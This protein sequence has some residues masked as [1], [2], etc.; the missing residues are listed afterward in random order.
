LVATRVYL[1][2][3]ELGIKSTAIV[4]KCQSEGLDIKGPNQKENENEG[5]T[6]GKGNKS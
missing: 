3:K 4:K 1:L 5:K 2:A 6:G